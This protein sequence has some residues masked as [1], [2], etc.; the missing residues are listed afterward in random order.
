MHVWKI[1]YWIN[2]VSWNP[3][4]ASGESTREQTDMCVTLLSKLLNATLGEML[5]QNLSAHES[6]L[7]LCLV[8]L[9]WYS[10]F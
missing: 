5:S 1:P 8:A 7:L 10:G 6:N 3:F 4:A 9:K 2:T